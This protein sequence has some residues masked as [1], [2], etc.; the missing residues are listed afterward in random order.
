M[1]AAEVYALPVFTINDM[2]GFRDDA[3]RLIDL[4]RGAA[5]AVA[6]VPGAAAAAAAPAVIAFDPEAGFASGELKWLAAECL[7]GYSYGQEVTLVTQP[8]VKG[9]KH[10]QDLPGGLRIFVECVA[11]ED[12][13]ARSGGPFK[14]QA[15]GRDVD[16][17]PTSPTVRGSSFVQNPEP[18]KSTKGRPGFQEEINDFMDQQWRALQLTSLGPPHLYR[19]RHGGASFE[20]AGKHR[21]MVGIQARSSWAMCYSSSLVEFC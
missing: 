16:I 11:G 7:G 13:F 5:P 19:L 17:G 12:Y 15:V 6:P 14:D 3:R 18:C 10:V 20:A 4:Q 8:L 21:D 9:S 2:A 1:T